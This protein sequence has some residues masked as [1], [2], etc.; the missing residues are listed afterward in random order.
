MSYITIN[1]SLSC[2][3]N[4]YIYIYLYMCVCLYVPQINSARI[5]VSFINDIIMPKPRWPN[6]EVIMLHAFVYNFPD[7]HLNI[8]PLF[9][10]LREHRHFHIIFVQLHAIHWCLRG[11]VVIVHVHN[12]ATQ[13]RLTLAVKCTQASK[14]SLKTID[15]NISPSYILC[16]VTSYSLWWHEIHCIADQRLFN[17]QQI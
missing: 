7:A 16:S 3:R 9:H 17:A 12:C 5:L 10:C 15:A 6:N 1:V 14:L 8:L 13:N 11:L 2:D 4:A